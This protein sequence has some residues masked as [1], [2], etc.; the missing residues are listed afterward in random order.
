MSAQLAVALEAVSP[1]DALDADELLLWTTMRTFEVQASAQYIAHAPRLAPP[2]AGVSAALLRIAGD[3]RPLEESVLAPTMKALVGSAGEAR[4]EDVILVVQGLVLERV[5]QVVYAT[6]TGLPRVP[7]RSK[8][9][10][11]SLEPVS[12][13]IMAL[14]PPL[15]AAA[16]DANGQKP[17]SFFVEASDDV[18]HKLDAV[19]EGVDEAFGPCFGLRFADIVGDFVADLVPVCVGLG[20]ERRK[21]MAHL[22]GALM[23][24]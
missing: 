15:F 1:A 3:D 14:V 21:V 20:M 17:F 4:D 7:E 8:A 6:L 5:R 19:G 23:G 16:C 9:I 22:A 12:A 18:L 10:A 13:E 24:I 2:K 11:R